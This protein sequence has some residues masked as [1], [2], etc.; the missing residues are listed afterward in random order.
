MSSA[1]GCARCSVSK[2]AIDKP[3]GNAKPGHAR[4]AEIPPPL[5]PAPPPPVGGEAWVRLHK[6]LRQPPGCAGLNSSVR[7]RGNLRG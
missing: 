1:D 4:D 2:L 7:G 5:I 3:A 6:S